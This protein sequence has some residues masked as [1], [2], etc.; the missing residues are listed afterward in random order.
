MK[1]I[2]SGLLLVLFSVLLLTSC[3]KNTDLLASDS[4]TQNH[5]GVL[6]QSLTGEVT[7]AITT[8]YCSAK[9]VPICAGQSNN[10]GTVSVQTA[11]NGKTYITY[12]LKSYW[13][14]Q[15]LH[16]Y[17]GSQDRIPVS[18]GGNANPGQFPFSKVFTAP[19]SCNKYTFVIDSLPD[20]Y[21]VAA[22]SA[23]VKIVNGVQVDAQ[24]G[25]GDGCSGRLINA[26]GGGSWG[27][28][29]TYSG[30]MCTLA[31]VSNNMV[32]ICSYPVTS[33]FGV[34]PVYGVVTNWKDTAVVV[35]AYTYS[36][37][38]GR[39]IAAAPDPNGQI[40]DAKFAFMRLATLKLSHTNYSQ[41]PALALP[42]NTIETWLAGQDKLSPT[43]LPNGNFMARNAAMIIDAWIN[44][45]NCPER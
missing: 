14:F 12:S 7:D 27:T 15:E 31:S 9:T 32:D 33:F 39:A 45:H 5:D 23:I 6:V 30:A 13:Y 16:L 25:W 17:V 1:T 3:K 22:H 42:A 24:T 18:G 19:Y 43:N 8:S 35:G 40:N 21:V 37:A 28:F 29:F 26:A 41:N 2:Y 36:E 44:T 38:E 11:I 34:H 20:F 10:V 4:S